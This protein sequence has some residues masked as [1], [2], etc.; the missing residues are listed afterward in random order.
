M[1]SHSLPL[2]FGT[3]ISIP[4]I[5]QVNERKKIQIAGYQYFMLKADFSG[6]PSTAFR[7][8][9]HG[10]PRM[11]TP[12]TTT[13]NKYLFKPNQPMTIKIESDG[14]SDQAGGK[15]RRIQ[16]NRSD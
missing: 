2:F 7:K 12:L 1:V 6:R 9:I 10:V 3:L 15:K 11:G 13:P 8:T 5:S 4:V 16:S 14:A